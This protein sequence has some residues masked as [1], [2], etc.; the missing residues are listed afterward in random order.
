MARSSPW[1]TRTT[2]PTKDFAL[3]RYNPDGSLDDSFGTG[4]RVLT[5][6]GSSADD[7]AR[8]VA[9]QSDGK[10]VVAGVASVSGGNDFATARY[11]VQLGRWTRA[12]A[13]WSAKPLGPAS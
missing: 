7:E 2:A 3:A 5:D 8:A 13:R 4:G 1:A 9:L 6:F 10:I 11:N 12:S